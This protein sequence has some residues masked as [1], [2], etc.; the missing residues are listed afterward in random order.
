MAA[1]QKSSVPPKFQSDFVEEDSEEE[2]VQ[3]CRFPAHKRKEKDNSTIIVFEEVPY[4]ETKKLEPEKSDMKDCDTSI[5]I[6]STEKN[7]SGDFDLYN[8]ACYQGVKQNLVDITSR[9][10]FEAK[11]VRQGSTEKK[12]YKYKSSLVMRYS[13]ELEMENRYLRELLRI[14]SRCDSNKNE[15]N[16]STIE[17]LSLLNQKKILSDCLPS[18]SD[19]NVSNVGAGQD[20]WKLM[21]KI[22]EDME[23]DKND[24]KNVAEDSDADTISVN[25]DST[26]DLISFSSHLSCSSGYRSSDDEENRD[27]TAHTI[28]KNIIEELLGDIYI[29]DERKME[30]YDNKMICGLKL[31]EQESSD[32]VL[33]QSSVDIP[34]LESVVDS[35]KEEASDTQRVTRR[36]KITF[37]GLDGQILA[38]SS[39]DILDNEDNKYVKEANSLDKKIKKNDEEK[40]R[41][42]KVSAEEEIG[43]RNG[44]NHVKESDLS[45]SFK[46]EPTKTERHLHEPA[47]RNRIIKSV[48]ENQSESKCF[49]FVDNSGRVLA[50]SRRSPNHQEQVVRKNV[51]HT[52]TGESYRTDGF[53]AWQKLKQISAQFDKGTQSLL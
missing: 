47:Q 19:V 13:E 30:I 2:L 11:D 14:N 36:R 41:C 29:Q 24:V 5:K 51:L 27:D 38:V 3:C 35:I 16:S 9:E 6:M 48:P 12:I 46:N 26:L 22:S 49:L 43:R 18:K 32:S 28:V 15:N 44:V 21:R 20:A 42:K 40:N 17:S 53:S 23:R 31:G 37:V 45:K 33:S 34:D 39:Q 1:V 52:C 8:K 10:T 50:G 7:K 4:V 25:S